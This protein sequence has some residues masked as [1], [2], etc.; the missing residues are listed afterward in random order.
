MRIDCAMKRGRFI[1]KVNSLLQEFHFT[2]PQVKM[3]IVNIFATSFYGSG[4]W[5]LQSK[6]VDRLYK[7]WNV[8]VRMVFGVPPTTHRYLVEPL[9]GFPHAKTM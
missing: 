4:L 3:K 2:E 9:A 5:D 8:M 7:S 1:G 6:D